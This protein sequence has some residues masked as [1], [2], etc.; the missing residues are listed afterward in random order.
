MKLEQERKIVSLMIKLYYKK[1]PNEQEEKELLTYV[2]LRLSKC[3]FKDNKTFCS[4]CKVHCYK[5]DM[6]EKIKKVMRYSGPRMLIYHPLL[7]IKHVRET[8]KE[9]IKNGKK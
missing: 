4:N 3:P 7:A 1:H 6:R 2:Y 8:I 9:K 5:P